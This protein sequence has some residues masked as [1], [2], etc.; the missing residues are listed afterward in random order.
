MSGGSVLIRFFC[1]VFY[2]ST[3]PFFVETGE[4]WHA[5]IFRD[6]V[7]GLGSHVAAAG[8]DGTLVSGRGK[9]AVKSYGAYDN[10]C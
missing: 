10:P 5:G 9:F 3:G 4:G 6:L 8:G 1:F 7:V 2:G